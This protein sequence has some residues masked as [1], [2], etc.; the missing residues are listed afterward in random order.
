MVRFS[1]LQLLAECFKC[2]FLIKQIFMTRRG[3]ERARAWAQVR[4]SSLVPCL[5]LLTLL[6]PHPASAVN[7]DPPDRRQHR[8]WATGDERQGISGPG[9]GA[10]LAQ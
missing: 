1:A 3:W 9:A 2:R 8:D 4:V 10:H 6:T 7:H 5:S